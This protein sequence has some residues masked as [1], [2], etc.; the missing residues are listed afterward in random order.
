MAK[1]CRAFTATA[2]LAWAVA[3]TS[4]PKPPPP[5]PPPTAIP[6]PE[7]L[8]C[9]PQAETETN[10]DDGRDDD[11]NGLVDCSD[12]ACG[13][14]SCGL[15]G[16]T[17]QSGACVLDGVLD[18]RPP[19]VG[20]TRRLRGDS[21]VF[22]FVPVEGARDY[23]IWAL[24]DPNA[25]QKRDDGS[26]FVPGA[27]Y[28]CA[29]DR[30]LEGWEAELAGEVL[31]YARSEEEALL[32]YAYPVG[33]PD[34]LPVFALGHPAPSSDDP[35]GSAFAVSRV[36]IYTASRA[37][38]DR[39]LEDGYRDDGVA[40]Y[41]PATGGDRDVYFYVSEPQAW[42]Q[43]RIYYLYYV[44]EDE[45]R[46]RSGQGGKE[47]R[48][49][50]LLGE[51]REGAMPVYRVHHEG[52]D[53]LA[54]GGALRDRY[55][56]QGNQPVSQ[57]AWS[58]LTEKTTLVIE[59]LDRGCPFQGHYAA[60]D[61]EP[62]G[63][64]KPFLSL[65]RLLRE[66]P[67]REYWVNGQFDTEGRPQVLARSFVTV[68]PGGVPSFD[69]YA[70]FQ[71]SGT[72]QVYRE[73]AR[74]SG[75]R[76]LRLSSELFDVDFTNIELA[77]WSLGT[78]LGQL[79]VG[80]ADW[81]ADT[82]G[83]FRLTAKRMARLE[84]E[85]FVHVVAQMDIPSTRRRYPQIL[86]SDQ[87]APVQANL[88]KG[89][90]VIVQPFGAVTQLQIQLCHRRSWD[91]NDQCP[92][93]RLGRSWEFD[94][95]YGDTTTP[96]QPSPVAGEMSGFDLPVT[97]EVYV[98]RSRVYV[99]ANEKPVGCA[100]IPSGTWKE[101][102]VSVTLGDVLYHSGVDEE[103][104]CSDCAHQFLRRFRLEQTVRRF[105]SFAFRSGVRAPPWNEV[106]MPCS[107]RLD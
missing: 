35:T 40:F 83:K 31:D 80:Y 38:R 86:V 73:T 59:A 60:M 61:T 9:E 76:S 85:R 14:A 96:W 19:L 84:T 63:Y 92:L 55:L 5:A 56:Y 46:E 93:F 45:R 29:G 81:A 54:L 20:L 37:I 78:A 1:H 17:C 58:G 32:G 102:P 104:V 64:A 90:T 51:P 3:C 39:L 22:S 91:V 18:T 42:D 49:F 6:P 88:E 71:T 52:H 107:T 10:C 79:W 43:D 12:A 16:L 65:P 77:S 89:T 100:Q 7:P 68:A 44:S 36:T 33:A 25:L 98:S 105:D 99:F 24:P 21:V 97:F 15:Y 103:V 28:R 8:L 101:G 106:I 62:A 30:P 47:E 57:L 13:G 75:S 2:V 70:D 41:V 50:G 23:R 27:V 94:A 66:E 48:V 74:D 26:L 87:P 4:E 69:F 34:R 95:A 72:R 82:N 67:A 11:C 53:V